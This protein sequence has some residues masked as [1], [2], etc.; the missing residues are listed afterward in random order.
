[1]TQT[2]NTATKANHTVYPAFRKSPLEFDPKTILSL[3]SLVK[4]TNYG[5][6]FLS[7]SLPWVC[8]KT[9]KQSPLPH[10][11]NMLSLGA[12]CPSLLS[13]FYQEFF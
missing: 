10:F 6:Q 4:N 3:Y 5:V 2:K 8:Q 11:D 9:E 13:F 12:W 1:M 7:P